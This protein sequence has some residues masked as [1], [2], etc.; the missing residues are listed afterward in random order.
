MSAQIRGTR[1][2]LLEVMAKQ[3]AACL[4]PSHRYYTYIHFGV[5]ELFLWNGLITIKRMNVYETDAGC[6]R[7]RLLATVLLSSL[8]LTVGLHVMGCMRAR[9]LA[10]VLLFSLSLCS[11]EHIPLTTDNV[12]RVSAATGRYSPYTP[13][14]PRLRFM[15]IWLFGIPKHG[16]FRN[17]SLGLIKITTDGYT[18]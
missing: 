1:L 10:S 6:M 2:G 17:P 9:L 14:P 8:Y 3:R 18:E 11:L 13:T 15:S 12:P 7:A 4:L 5:T 16:L